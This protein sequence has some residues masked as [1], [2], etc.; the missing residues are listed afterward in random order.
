[1]ETISALPAICAGKSSVTDE[2]LA[3]W[4]VSWSFDFFICAWI[5]RWV[6]NRKVGDLRRH[7]AHYDVIEMPQGRRSTVA[8]PLWWLMKYGV[9]LKRDP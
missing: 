7:R 9:T 3:K 6:N 8:S 1:M 2:F 4:Q 5:I